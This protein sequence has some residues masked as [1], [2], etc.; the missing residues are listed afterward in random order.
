MPL[1]PRRLPRI[2]AERG[3]IARPWRIWLADNLLRGVPQAELLAT[4]VAHEVPP[5]LAARGLRAA[6]RSPEL[7]AARKRLGA[8]GRQAL[9]S[10]LRRELL[11]LRGPAIDRRPLPPPELFLREYYATGTPLVITDLV[12]RWPAFT[13]W[14][15]E[16]LREQYGTVEIEIEIGR[17]ADPAPDMHFERH[18]QPSTMAAYVDRV[19]AAGQTNDLYLIANNRN[20]ARPGLRGLLADIELPA[21]YF[22]TSVDR[23]ARCGALW[24]GPAGT[25]TALHHD[26]SNILLCQVRGH[27]RLRLFPPDEPRLLSAAHGVYNELDPE[28]DAAILAG[29][30]LDLVLAP[31][32]ALF[33][34]VGWW[35]HVR[36][37]DLSMSVALN[38]F[39]R[40]QDFAWYLPGK[41]A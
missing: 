34:P 35:H 22:G 20:L 36:A 23:A 28:R 24:F 3:A 33:L 16:H 10:R 41:H 39:A 11:A 4:L 21:G 15:P 19:L 29:R 38:A 2:R 26:T 12:T 1:R 27:K 37:L 14:T 6:A 32:E 8:A 40:P 17:A 31:G 25:V 30:G 5:S 9:A 7:E 13:R 18:R